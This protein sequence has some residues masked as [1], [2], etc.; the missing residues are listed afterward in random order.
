MKGSKQHWPNP[1][2]L[3]GVNTSFRPML[4]AFLV[5]AENGN[6]ALVCKLF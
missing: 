5:F 1:K 4:K 6:P 2:Q 3:A